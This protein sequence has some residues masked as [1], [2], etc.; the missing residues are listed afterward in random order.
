[1]RSA[2][3]EDNSNNKSLLFPGKVAFQLY[4]TYGFPLDLTQIMANEIG[5]T[6]DID[7]FNKA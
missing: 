2:N 1:M 3:A 6:V 4:T 7:E 5:Y